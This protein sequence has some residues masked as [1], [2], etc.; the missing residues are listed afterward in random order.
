MI[1][2]KKKAIFKPDS[3]KMKKVGNVLNARNEF[4]KNKNLHYLLKNRFSWMKQFINEDDKGLEVGAGAGFSKFF[5]KNK[6]F[7]ISDLA[8]CDHLDLKNI[9]AQN[10]NFKSSSFDFV[11]A[12]NMIHHVPYPIKFLNE[13]YRILKPKGRLII[14]DAHS[15]VIFQLITLIMKHEGFDFT[16]NVWDENMPMSNESDRWAGNIA[17]TNLIFDNLD[18]FN[19]KFSDKFFIRHQKFYE[20]FVFLNSGGVSSKTIYIPLNNF[21]LKILSYI[22][23]ILIKC[24]PN[25]FA[26]GR[27]IVLEKRN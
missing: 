4:N 5:I 17:V 9:D 18:K 8:D 12:V 20:C 6:N 10:T 15:S 16:K 11:I 22:D 19:E 13:M 2:I 26:M 1:I 14:Q 7:L 25:I 23:K 27:Q 24:F 21:F 3:N